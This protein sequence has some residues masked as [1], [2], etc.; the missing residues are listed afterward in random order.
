MP[1]VFVF[2]LIQRA[3]GRHKY[4][5]SQRVLVAV[6]LHVRGFVC[7]DYRSALIFYR[8]TAQACEIFSHSDLYAYSLIRF[9]SETTSLHQ[10]M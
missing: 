2:E 10:F 5:Y 6:G 1:L 9:T 8:E 7:Q 3:S 4:G